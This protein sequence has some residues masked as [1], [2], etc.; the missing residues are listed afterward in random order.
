MINELM[1]T[2]IEQD[3]SMISDEHTDRHSDADSDNYIG[4]HTHND[5][6]DHCDQ[7]FDDGEEE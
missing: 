7:M 4:G 6:S 1:D 2:Y 5:Y 3:F